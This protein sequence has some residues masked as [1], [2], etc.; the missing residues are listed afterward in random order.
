[1]VLKHNVN[2]IINVF[3]MMNKTTIFF[4]TTLLLIFVSCNGIKVGS[5]EKPRSV[6][7]FNEDWTFQLGDY[8]KASSADFND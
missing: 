6:N 3:P 1:M 7:N 8:S 2:V 5:E 4:L